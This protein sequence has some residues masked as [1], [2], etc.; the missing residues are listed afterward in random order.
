MSGRTLDN[1]RSKP[2]YLNK[3]PRDLMW[4]DLCGVVECYFA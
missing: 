3:T 1:D 2:R 4:L